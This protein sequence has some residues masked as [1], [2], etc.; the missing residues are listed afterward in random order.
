MLFRSSRCPSPHRRPRRWWVTADKVFETVKRLLAQNTQ[1]RV[2]RSDDARRSIEFT[3]GTQ[4][5][6]IQ[7]NP[8]NDK[9]S[10]MMVSTAHPGIA[11][12]T[13]STIVARILAMC[14]EL[15][16]VCEQGQS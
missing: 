10:Q 3:D 9:L 14:R 6:G 2:T 13:T 7:V 4:I 1:V 12:S 15:N 16:V 5:G 11:T 8:L